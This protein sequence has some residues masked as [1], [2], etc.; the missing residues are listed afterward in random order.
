MKKQ[1]LLF[2][3]IQSLLIPSSVFA[4]E[5]SDIERHEQADLELV[6]KVYQF[7]LD[8]YPL[9]AD[10]KK[11]AEAGLKGM[12][13]SLDPYS[14]YYT[15]EEATALFQDLEGSYSGIG[16]YI[17]QAEDHIRV[18]EPIKGSN[19]EK[20]GIIKGD[21]IISIDGIDTKGM[22]ASDASSKI[23]GPSGTS[24]MLGIRRSGTT[25]SLFYIIERQ[26]IVINP[27][28]YEIINNSIGYIKLTSFPQSAYIQLRAALIEFDKK[29]IEKVIL[30][31]RDNGGGL[32]N[33]AVSISGL[34]V[35]E[36]PV[37][38]IKEKNKELYTFIS[39]N[40]A[41]KYQLV[42]LVNEN[43]ASASEIFTGAIKD[44]N[45]GIIVGKKTFGKGIVQSIIPLM[46]GGIIKMTTSEYLTPNQT[47]IHG[48][49]IQ[50]HIEI[51][52]SATEDLQL[53]KAV[54]ILSGK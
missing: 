28:S 2:L 14:D 32:L 50:P 30:D 45:A 34:F 26:E 18:I 33:Q 8:S 35:P 16:L 42:L 27:V 20:A 12:L 6:N 10:S 51:T 48:I 25:D 31:I 15:A 54:E 38:Y 36:G 52:N 37:V 39:S 44:R 13:Q 53:K 47:R 21:I 40:K 24:V 5:Q 41:P 22:N 19:A 46:N 11:L 3:I 9:G 23:K 17:E 1:L 4:V 29:S 49:G 7:I 43:S